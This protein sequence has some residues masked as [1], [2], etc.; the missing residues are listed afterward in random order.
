MATPGIITGGD[1][2]KN[3]AGLFRRTT[4]TSEPV[5]GYGVFGRNPGATPKWAINRGGRDAE[6]RESMARL[7]VEIPANAMEAFLATVSAE[8][9]PLARVLA[10]AG[11]G[12]NTGGTGFLDFLLTRTQENFQEKAQIVDTLTDN[13]VAFYSGLAPPAFQY[14]GT[15]LNTYQDDQRVW[16]LRLYREILRGS[17][18]AGRNLIAR[19]RYDS[20]IV[21]GYLE[22]LTLGLSGQTDHVAS[23]FNFSLRVK[24]LNIFTPALGAPTVA[25]TAATTNTI[26]QGEAEQRDAAARA[27][28]VTPETPINANASPG[29]TT[30]TQD[31]RE[32]EVEQSAEG[33]QRVSEQVADSTDPNPDNSSADG[34][35]GQTNTMGVSTPSSATGPTPL[36]PRST[37]RTRGARQGPVPPP[38]PLDPPPGQ[39]TGI[40]Q[41]DT[42]SDSP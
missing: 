39:G 21:S 30:E 3:V 6:K 29:A 28:A 42:T 38:P 2:A 9:R 26:L 16:M 8:T 32:T 22:A 33:Q 4:T 36:T 20:F 19:L 41:A 7:F 14:T 18:L 40:T 34:A 5:S 37:P 10:I 23:T 12:S 13:Y 35:D 24:R 17:R 27:G 11:D 1:G 25:Q 15:L 31:P